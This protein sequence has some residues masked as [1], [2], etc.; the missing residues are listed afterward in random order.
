MGRQQ[1]QPFKALHEIRRRAFNIGQ[2]MTQKKQQL[3]R[4]M[5]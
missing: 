2:R 5:N 4:L 1:P 3:R